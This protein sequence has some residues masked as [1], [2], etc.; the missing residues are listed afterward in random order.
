MR[1]KKGLKQRLNIEIDLDVY[2]MAKQRNDISL[3]GEIN[4]LLRARLEIKKLENINKIKL[5]EEISDTLVK[6][7]ELQRLL[8][9]KKMLLIDIEEKEKRHEEEELKKAEM[10][11]DGIK[12]NNPL[13]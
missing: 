9:E 4:K 10:I 8:T 1:E 3:S 2:L 12:A 13:R 7:K 6:I 5:M 11:A